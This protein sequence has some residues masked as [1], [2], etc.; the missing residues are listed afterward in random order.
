MIIYKITN[1]QD[2]DCLGSVLKKI[3]KSKGLS[4]IEVAEAADIAINSL[5]LYESNKR[6]PGFKQLVSILAVLGIT[7]DF[8]AKNL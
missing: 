8:T 1:T 2:A 4:Q 7:L 3:R 6:Q 5:R